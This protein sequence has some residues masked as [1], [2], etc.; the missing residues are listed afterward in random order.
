VV[1]VVAGIGE[2]AGTLVA[3][4]VLVH[5][6]PGGDIG[7]DMLPVVVDTVQ[8]VDRHMDSLLPV[9]PEAHCSRNM[10]VA[11]EEPGSVEGIVR[12]AALVVEMNSIAEEDIRAAAEGI[13][14][15]AVVGDDGSFVPGNT[16]F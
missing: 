8:A 13:L 7:P 6:V 10:A 1:L 14:L 16:T 4:V 12:I 5:T 15:V 9:L 11:E 3:L 2:P